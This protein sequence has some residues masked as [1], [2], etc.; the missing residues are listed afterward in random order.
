MPRASPRTGRIVAVVAAA[1]LVLSIAAAATFLLLRDGSG[2]DAA[3]LSDEDARSRVAASLEAASGM[4]AGEEPE[5]DL[6]KAEATAWPPADAEAGGFLDG[7]G[8]M[9]MVMEWGRDGAQQVTIDASNGPVTF[10]LTMTCTKE[11]RAMEYGG[12]AFV[13]RP[14]LD[15]APDCA[16]MGSEE[17]GALGEDTMPLEGL[18]AVNATLAVHDD[19]S[20][21]AEV[22]Q[23]GVTAQ[24][25][26]D[27]QGRLTSL[28]ATSPEQGSW[29]MTYTYGAR[30]QLSLPV[31]A[32]LMPAE[33][34]SSPSAGYGALQTWTVASS[35]QAPPLSEMEVRVQPYDFDEGGSNGSGGETYSFP[36]DVAGP[37]VQG[38]Y[39]VTYHDADGDGKVSKGDSW[40]SYD[41]TGVGTESDWPGIP[42]QVLLYDKAAKGAVN[43]DPL[44]M[45]G[46]GW[47]PLAGLALGL[48]LLRRR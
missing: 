35:P 37:Q 15:G 14:Y 13:S 21:H 9:H 29:T 41:A 7:I 39:T 36:A 16:D 5:D 24:L 34:E 48:A 42:P 44:G 1:V 17:E 22:S 10:A 6:V 20:I 27:P 28:V 12:E 26:L 8:H 30:R 38:N 3:S 23:D 31:N 25:D 2:P 19:G 45:P 32:K 4:F 33:V 11:R 43:S 46:L 47:V 18:S 40:E